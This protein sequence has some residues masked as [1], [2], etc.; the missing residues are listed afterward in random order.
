MSNVIEIAQQFLNLLEARDLDNVKPLISNDFTMVW[1]GDVRIDDLAAL[2]AFGSGRFQS[3]K[4]VYDSIE[5]ADTTSGTTV[6]SVGT[7]EGIFADGS[8]FSGI[9]FVDR[10][11]VDREGL[12]SELFVWSDLGEELRKRQL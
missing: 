2:S 5:A 11:L 10:V 1:P 6:Y 4:N 9:R 8:A 12:V 7:L 3:V